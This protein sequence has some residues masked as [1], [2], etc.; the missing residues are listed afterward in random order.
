MS[1]FEWGSRPNTTWIYLH[2]TDGELVPA[3]GVGWQIWLVDLSCQITL[4]GFS[5]SNARIDLAN[6]LAPAADIMYVAWNGLNVSLQAPVGFG[7]NH[8]I[9]IYTTGA[10]V[11]VR[12]NAGY[13]VEPMKS[14]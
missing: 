5:T 13:Y 10:D 2:D 14:I 11:D 8:P 12:V 7:E 3:P 6:G 1:R 9:H 4:S